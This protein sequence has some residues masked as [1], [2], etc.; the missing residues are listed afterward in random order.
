[1]TIRMFLTQALA[2]NGF[3]FEIKLE[4]PNSYKALSEEEMFD[5]LAESRG[6]AEMGMYKEASVVSQDY[7]SRMQ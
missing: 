2:V 7:E 6:Q 1:M 3:S 5:K 4:N